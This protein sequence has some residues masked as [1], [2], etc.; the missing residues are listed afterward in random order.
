MYIHLGQDD[1]FI[2]VVEDTD[3][4]TYIYICLCICCHIDI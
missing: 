3:T 2:Q 4:Y 1:G